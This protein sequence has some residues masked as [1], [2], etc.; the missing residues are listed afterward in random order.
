VGLAR[1]GVATAAGAVLGFAVSL[2]ASTASAYCRTTTCDV[3][4]AAGDCS[5][6]ADK[7][8]TSG[9]PLYWPDSCGWFGIQKDGS[10]KRHISYETFHSTVVNAFGKW[11][12][13]NCGGGAVPSFALEDTDEL[14]GPVECAKH[15]F[16]KHAANASTWMFLDDGW[17]YV[18]ATTTIALTT[19]SVDIKTG[20]ILDADVEINSF[21]TNITTSDVNVGADLDSIV[22]HESGH[23]LGL[24]HSAV[25]MSTMFP[26]YPGI[27]I[28][29]LH[30]DDEEGICAAYPPSKPPVCGQPEPLY[31]F[32]KECGGANPVTQP[33]P[34]G[35][36]KTNGCAVALGAPSGAPTTLI[37]LALVSGLAARRRRRLP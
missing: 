4:N 12:K 9:A 22:T 30:P 11:A 29:S 36:D 15:E 13:A 2:H 19:L 6:D 33:E 32:S 10:P 1:G 5:W 8:A 18:G 31:G 37:G 20:R 3:D 16:N 23:F 26:N 14:Y 27:A 34:S 28:R 17:P 24:A 35:S 7:C 21:G 25:G